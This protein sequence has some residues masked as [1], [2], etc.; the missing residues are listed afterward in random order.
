MKLTIAA[1]GLFVDAGLDGAIDDLDQVV[2]IGRLTP[3]RLFGEKV[4]PGV[5]LCERIADA[6]RDGDRLL[7]MADA[8]VA[9]LQHLDL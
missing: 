7:G 5:H 1:V 4:D 3:R 8:L 2:S 9:V 6:P